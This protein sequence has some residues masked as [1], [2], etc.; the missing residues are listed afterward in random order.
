MA[1]K[2]AIDRGSHIPYTLIAIHY[3]D[4]DALVA[5]LMSRSTWSSKPT[6]TV[7]VDNSDELD[8]GK[9]D[10]VVILNPGSNLG[11]GPAVN[12]AVK[13]LGFPPD[14]YLLI[15]TQDARLEPSCTRILLDCL[16]RNGETSLAA[17]VLM[18][19]S[20]PHV[21]FSAG[22]VLSSRGETSHEGWKA[23]REEMPSVGEKYVD[24]ADGACLMLRLEDFSNVG[25][26]DE[27]Y[28]LY[29]EEVDLQLRLRS[30]GGQI[31]ICY[32][33]VAF[34]E[35]GNY[36]LYYKYRN[37]IYL[38]RR[39]RNILSPWPW[40]RKVPMDLARAMLKRKTSEVP[41]I[42]RGIYDGYAGR[43]GQPP[44]GLFAHSITGSIIG[45][46]L[47]TVRSHATRLLARLHLRLGG[48]R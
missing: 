2:S 34:Q 18:F 4:V 38:S 31:R 43:T 35:P 37:H 48:R 28:F 42:L 45:Y 23:R 40:H 32:E 14:P 22:G 30:A 11:Y 47:E 13:T 29:V 12:W 8:P 39:Q 3:R 27:N 41:W 24:W 36:R 33:A 44:R 20:N 19:A 15:V 17:P 5:L 26:F 1:D 16:A 6:H 46:D 10:D 9:W 21:V 7:V 25:G